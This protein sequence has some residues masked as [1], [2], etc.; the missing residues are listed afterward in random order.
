MLVFGV[1][2]S[3]EVV[4]VYILQLIDMYGDM[5]LENVFIADLKVLDQDVCIAHQ[6][7][8]ND[9]TLKLYYEQNC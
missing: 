7:C 5:V 1:A 8:T 2:L 9:K 6:K 4:D 3:L